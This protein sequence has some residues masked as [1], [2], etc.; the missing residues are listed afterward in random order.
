MNIFSFFV[1]LAHITVF[2]VQTAFDVCCVPLVESLN[3][4][5]PGLQHQS[6][7]SYHESNDDSYT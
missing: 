6:T 5:L 4:L 1:T 2:Y 7:K 3:C